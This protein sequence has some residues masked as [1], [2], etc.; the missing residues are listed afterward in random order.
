[1]PIILMNANHTKFEKPVRYV[2]KTFGHLLTHIITDSQHKSLFDTEVVSKAWNN[3]TIEKVDQ[4][5]F[6]MNCN[7]AKDL[8]D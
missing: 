5:I 4:Q 7:F 1:M 3:F 2:T 8:L 6:F